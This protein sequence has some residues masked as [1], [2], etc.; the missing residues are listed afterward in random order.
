MKLKI[1]KVKSGPLLY[2]SLELK[3]IE[4]NLVILIMTES[5]NISLMCLKYDL[6]KF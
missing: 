6:A 5:I 1:L 2:L 4:C 3:G